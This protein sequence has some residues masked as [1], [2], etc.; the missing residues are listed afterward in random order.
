MVN[1]RSLN[2]WQIPFWFFSYL[3]KRVTRRIDILNLPLV[4]YVSKEHSN[5]IVVCYL[6]WEF[7]SSRKKN[8]WNEWMIFFFSILILFNPFPLKLCHVHQLFWVLY[9]IIFISK[10][11]KKLQNFLIYTLVYTVNSHLYIASF[12]AFF[13]YTTIELYTWRIHCI[14][15]WNLCNSKTD[16]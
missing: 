15:K 6:C 1:M 3:V 16:V 9:C 8:L 4:L 13:I 11:H 7:N 14:W 5:I 2:K 12:I 10:K